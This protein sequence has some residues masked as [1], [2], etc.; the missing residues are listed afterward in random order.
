MSSTMSTP[1]VYLTFANHPDQHLALLES[2]QN[3]ILAALEQLED[4]G[5]LEVKDRVGTQT[6]HIFHDLRRYR[7][8]VAVYHYAGH[9]NSDHLQLKNA[10]GEMVE[11]FSSGLAKAL[12][13]ETGIQLVFLNGC[14]T[15]AQVHDLLEN[16]VPA[17]IATSVPVKDE[18]A[19]DFALEFYKELANNASI[20]DAFD[21]ASNLV[22]T[23]YSQKRSF[24]TTRGGRSARDSDL[25]S[26]WILATSDD[27]PEAGQWVLTSATTPTQDSNRL[28]NT[29]IVTVCNELRKF[30]PVI[31]KH[32]EG[33]NLG[34]LKAEMINLLPL[35][36]GQQVRKLLSKNKEE[37]GESM[38][39]YSIARLAQLHYSFDVSVQFIT[40]ILLSQLWDE[41]VEN[42]KSLSQAL[43]SRL[44][45]YC[46]L[47]T[48]SFNFPDLLHA[49]IAHFHDHG[50]RPFLDEME[51]LRETDDRFSVGE[52][53]AFMAQIPEIVRTRNIAYTQLR[54]L[55]DQAERTLGALLKSVAFL[56]KYR[57]ATVNKIELV[58]RRHADPKYRH[59][60]IELNRAN[61]QFDENENR[62]EYTNYTD[63]NA[64]LFLKSDGKSVTDYL[65]LSPFIIDLNA[66]D[67]SS[68]QHTPMLY[69]FSH[70]ADEAHFFK[71]LEDPSYGIQRVDSELYKSV[72]RD[73][74]K[75]RADI[76]GLEFVEP[77]QSDPFDLFT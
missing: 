19:K 66:L 53:Y 36:I 34:L 3:G 13:A 31:Q 48:D 14:A 74:D 51:Q 43:R 39:Q 72:K 47:H 68:G 5:K 42:K 55:C 33:K 77:D 63:N 21:R 29:L 71:N 59:F 2:E 75:F 4:A 61:S 73:L 20:K 46:D 6:E 10:N 54:E 30:S 12:G 16:G 65:S 37:S 24:Q 25:S 49:L 67:E 50:I 15:G 18:M 1:I 28:N 57:F 60:N 56:T 11:A 9:A 27:K 17:V 40:Y 26:T 76:L 22:Q 41:Q 32:W 58:K 69:V 64:V 8:R 52:G 38:E 45:S 7:G 62:I 23:N 35:P 44:N 70:S